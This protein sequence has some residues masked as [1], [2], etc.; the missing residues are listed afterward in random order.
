MLALPGPPAHPTNPHGHLPL[1]GSHNGHGTQ[2]KCSKHHPENASKWV[3]LKSTTSPTKGPRTPPRPLS[4]LNTGCSRNG[5]GQAPPRCPDNKTSTRR[6]QRG[7][8]TGPRHMCMY[9]HS[10]VCVHVCV[11]RGMYTHR[12]VCCVYAQRSVHVC[13]GVCTY[14][15]V[16]VETRACTYTVVYVHLCTG[17]CAYTGV[18]V[19]IWTGICVYIGL[20]MHMC[21]DVCAYTDLCARVCAY[22]YY[23][24]VCV[25]TQAHMCVPQVH[26]HF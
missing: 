14:T 13:R 2:R 4:L 24:Q 16:C 9:T 23:V 10:C 25:Y 18:C 5:R 15:G 17:V 1:L 20:C 6:W 8:Q 11:V 7:D 19:H 3:V 12:C 21:T 22:G 26:F